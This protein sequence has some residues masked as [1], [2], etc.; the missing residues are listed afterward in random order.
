ME[1]LKNNET[2]LNTKI[3]VDDVNGLNSLPSEN[4]D[5]ERKTRLDSQ[6]SS[7]SGAALED[8]YDMLAQVDDIDNSFFTKGRD[9]QS[10][11][12]NH[13]YT[14]RE[15]EILGSYDSQDYL[16]PH[17]TA[18]TTWL[19]G[20][21]ARL[22]WDRWIMMGLIGFFTGLTGFFLHQIIDVIADTKWKIAKDFIND[23]KSEL[24]A[25]WITTTAYSSLFLLISSGIVVF[26]RPSAA[27]SGMPELIGFL[28]GTMIRHIFNLKTYVVKFFSCAL[29]VGAGM[30]VGPEGPM[31]H[32]GSMVGAG[33]SQ[34]QSKTLG[35]KLPFFERFRNSEDRR[36]FISAGAAAGIASAFGAPVGGL[37]FAM[38][39]VSSFWNMKLSWQVFFCSMV[40]AFTTDLFNSS[41]QGF[42]YTGSFGQFKTGQYILFQIEDGIDLNILGLIPSII[43][44]VLGGL[45]GSLF[46]FMNLKFAR[47]RLKAM[48]YV[49]NQK[50]VKLI[51]LMEPLTI[52]LITTTLSV[53]IPAAF[54]CTPLS[55]VLGLDEQNGEMVCQNNAGGGK[56]VSLVVA[57]PS[58]EKY[59]CPGNRTEFQN[60]TVIFN[61]SY[62]QAAT[63]FFVTGEKAIQ[64]LFSRNTHLEF[65]YAPLVIFFL[66]Y[67]FLACWAAGTQISCGLVVPMLLIG[68]LY[69]RILGRIAV[70]LFGVQ[71]GAYWQWM[72]P[73]AFALLGGASFFGG[74]TRLT[75]SLAVIMVEIT[76]D[77]QFLLLIIVTILFAKW[78]G[79]FFTHPL[80]HSFLEFR[81]IPFLD[82]E[83]VLIRENGKA[84][85]LETH[86][87]KEVMTTEVKTLEEVESLSHVVDLLQSNVHGGF[88]VVS[89]EKTFDGLIT[90]FDLMTILCKAFTSRAF[91]N[92]NDVIN[93]DIEYEEFNKMRGHKLSDPKLTSE[94]L[95]QAQ[96]TSSR[97]D[98][99]VDL[100]K[101]I[102]RSAMSVPERFSL[103]R[104][105][106]IFRSLGLRHLTIVDN[107]FHVTGIITR[108]DLMGFSIEEKLLQRKN[109]S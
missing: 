67:F 73:G 23:T 52:M 64:H 54:S 51:R 109:F 53:L 69:G 103:H 104:T 18:Y 49:T 72:D 46:I 30:P 96:K 78:T 100:R 94:L 92:A 37:L 32:L 83:P 27:G 50:Y 44:G 98:V 56:Y 48:S 3:S 19:S 13:Q 10:T 35:I 71:N 31:I 9:L 38:E 61:G 75:M 88:P 84:A 108:K 76:N 8:E 17:C 24:G 45:F 34:F 74:V 102:N 43:L 79:D 70:D 101:Y 107:N 68:G 57:K 82:A 42:Q 16:P 26:L 91:E 65:D 59:T 62:N 22:D 55:C 28:N 11:A 4:D 29:A 6:R 66:F 77:I 87:A 36:N 85:N 97:G 20:Q 33:L 12:V 81:C 63:L 41:F 5:K 39:E 60:G 1:V 47:L 90:R 80:Y 95:S 99:K 105:Y 2:S 93:M 89:K 86:T 21:P 40:S 7:I 58:V 25:A 15:K 14:E 106:N